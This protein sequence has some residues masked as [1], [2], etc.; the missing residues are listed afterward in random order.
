MFSKIM[1]HLLTGNV[2]LHEAP[3][4]R[5]SSQNCDSYVIIICNAKGLNF[6]EANADVYIQQLIQ[7]AVFP[8][9]RILLPS[10]PCQYGERC[11]LQLGSLSGSDAP[12]MQMK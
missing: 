12:H 6:L 8:E 2:Q 11:C 10:R 5:P 7:L 9:I 4:K 1:S 3:A